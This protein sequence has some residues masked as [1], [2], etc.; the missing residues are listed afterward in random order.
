MIEREAEKV[1]RVSLRRERSQYQSRKEISDFV[2]GQLLAAE[3]LYLRWLWLE[4]SSI[5]ES[6]EGTGTGAFGQSKI[7][8]S[9]CVCAYQLERQA[10][11]PSICD[12]PALER[13]S[14]GTRVTPQVSLS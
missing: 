7:L 2:L 13:S 5:V 10:R 9:V 6:V 8:L 11:K 3:S 4:K 14:Q 1:E 12:K